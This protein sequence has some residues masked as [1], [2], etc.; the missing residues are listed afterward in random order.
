[1]QLEAIEEMK[2][3]LEEMKSDMKANKS[4]IEGDMKEI[5]E[6]LAQLLRKEEDV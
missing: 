3:G 4:R 5:K 2:V 1:M 6:L